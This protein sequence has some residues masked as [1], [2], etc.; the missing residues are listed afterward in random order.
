MAYNIPSSVQEAAAQFA[1]TI[2]AS[3]N[4]AASETAGIDVMY[5]RA[6]PDKRS[7]DVIF[8]AYTLY[9]VEDC[10][11]TFRA[12]YS[13]TGY[14]DGA[15]TYNIMGLNFAIPMTMDIARKTWEEVTG[16]DGTIPQ[17]HDIVFIPMTRKLMEV[18]SMTPV[19]QLGGQLTSYKVNLGIY[20]PTRSRLVG[21]NLKDSIAQS[22]TNLDE[23]FGEDIERTLKDIVDPDQLSIHTSDVK[24]EQ[25]EVVPTRSNDS[26]LLDIRSIIDYDLIVDGHTI[27]RSYYNM[28]TSSDVVVKYKRGDTF[29]KTDNRCLTLWVRLHDN[30]ESSVKNIKDSSLSFTGGNYYLSTTI[31]KNFSTGENVV[32]KRGIITVHGKVVG[33]RR[34]KLNN[35]VVKK[36][37]KMN[38]NWYKMPGFAL[39]RDNCVNLL[40]GK[41]FNVSIKGN[42]TVAIRQNESET[43]IQLSNPL[44][45]LF[46]Y[47]LVINLGEQ[48]SVDVYG[49]ENGFERIENISGIDNK[50]YENVQVDNFYM[51]GSH[52]DITNIRFYTVANTEIDKQITDLLSYNA[53]NDSYAIIN[54]SADIYLNKPYVGRQH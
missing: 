7:Q 25:K 50:V 27:A 30:P 19:K 14:D 35:D 10:P 9:G 51:E 13:D 21:E 32:L 49:T 41:D 53:K 16:N 40:S 54:D 20:K 26:N 34:I 48:F 24:D 15:I 52:A 36:L 44:K 37:N 4:A 17:E 47:G 5:F 38:E 22:T 2:L 28:G 12:L 11:L 1:S 23:R 31:G 8:Q 18:V 45:E 6:T 3:V 46:W 39:M 33:S 29:T 43:I 42:D